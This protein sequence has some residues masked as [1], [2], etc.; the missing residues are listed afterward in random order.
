MKINQM[1]EMNEH[2]NRIHGSLSQKVVSFVLK[3]FLSVVLRQF[4]KTCRKI[5]RKLRI[6]PATKYND[7]SYDHTYDF[8]KT[9][10]PWQRYFHF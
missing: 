2:S 1:K 3:I 9:K 4:H 10:I 8:L 5:N 7:R 6:S